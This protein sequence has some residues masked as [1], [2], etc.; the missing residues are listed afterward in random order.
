MSD[1]VVDMDDPR[2]P[3]ILRALREGGSQGE[4]PL[5]MR[6]RAIR[7]ILDSD[8]GLSVA[9]AYALVDRLWLRAR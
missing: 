7:A 8:P 6:A 3:L 9:Q 4:D 5:T 1:I 2:A